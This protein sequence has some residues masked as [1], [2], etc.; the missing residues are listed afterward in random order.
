MLIRLINVYR[1]ERVNKCTA[2]EIHVRFIYDYWIN[3][4]IPSVQCISISQSGAFIASY[5]V[6]YKMIFLRQKKLATGKFGDFLSLAIF[7]KFS[8]SPN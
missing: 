1:V 2:C 3:E 8:C 6:L 4:N 7:A 5:E